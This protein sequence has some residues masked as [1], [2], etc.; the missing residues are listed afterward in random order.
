M[1]TW[2]KQPDIDQHEIKLIINISEESIIFENLTT[3]HSLK[4]DG[5]KTIKECRLAVALCDDTGFDI[6]QQ[7]G[8]IS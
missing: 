8:I 2:L 7:I 1:F 4:L 3:K 5:I 6:T